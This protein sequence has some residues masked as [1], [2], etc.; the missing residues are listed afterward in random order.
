MNISGKLLVTAAGLLAAATIFTPAHAAGPYGDWL[1]SNGA[2]IKVYKC[3][4]GVGM[5]VTKSDEAEKVG[6]VI[7][8]GAKA[9]GPNKWKGS[10]LN[11]DD[12]KTYKGIVTLQDDKK[13]KLQGCVLGGLICKSDTWTKIK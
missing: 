11:L 13:L 6:K 3:E 7:M 9:S 12:G 4:G 2:H 5:K 10:V 8:C 1:R